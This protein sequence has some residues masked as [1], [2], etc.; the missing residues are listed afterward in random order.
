MTFSTYRDFR[1]FTFS[2]SDFSTRTGAVVAF[3]S[4]RLPILEFR[5]SEIRIGIGADKRLRHESEEKDE[6][7]RNVTDA[8]PTRADRVIRD[9]LS[10]SL[11][12]ALRVL[13]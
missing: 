12:L 1:R 11:A 8:M 6:K 9:S 2:D 5:H 3:T 4:S 10:L 13:F 7:E